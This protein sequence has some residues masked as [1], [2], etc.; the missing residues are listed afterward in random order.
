MNIKPTAFQSKTTPWRVFAPIGFRGS[1]TRKP[2]YFATK[3]A[4]SDFC[5]EVN[6]WKDRQKHGADSI[7]TFEES[8]KRWMAYL[9]QEFP[10][11]S[12]L[13]DVVAHW[14]ATGPGAVAKRSLREAVDAY[15]VFYAK[16]K[17]DNELTVA[18]VTGKLRTFAAEYPG[19]G[20]HEVTRR[21]IKEYL[22]DYETASTRNQHLKKLKAFFTWTTV[23]R[24]SAINPAESIDFSKVD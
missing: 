22:E 8:Q 18:D 4:A 7:L 21:D 12:V 23:E 20:C 24:F 6:G 3:S 10:D 19:M 14:K 1:E 2:H 5:K 17:S 15:L 11:L 13:P 16:E 9:M